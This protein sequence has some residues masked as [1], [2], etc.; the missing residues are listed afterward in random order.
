MEGDVKTGDS[1]AGP[2]GGLAG[3][4]R[5]VLSRPIIF[6]YGYRAIMPGSG[7]GGPAAG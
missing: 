3:A 2:S 6:T 1:V 4:S 7:F 5:S